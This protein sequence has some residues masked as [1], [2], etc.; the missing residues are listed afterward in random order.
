MVLLPAFAGS[1][2]GALS[3]W[4]LGGVMYDATGCCGRGD[5]PGLSG[6]LGLA[7]GLSVLGAAAIPALLA[8]E[9]FP[10]LL[11]ASTIGVLPAALGAWAGLVVSDGSGAAAVFS[12]AA[13]HALFVQLLAPHLES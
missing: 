7:A 4:Y 2:A 5:D 11:S 9:D 1:S 3:G 8:D 6:R 13:T 10:P 12:Y